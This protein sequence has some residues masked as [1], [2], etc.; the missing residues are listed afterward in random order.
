MDPLRAKSIAL[1]QRVRGT[2]DEIFE[3]HTR[4]NALAILLYLF[5][6]SIATNTPQECDPETIE[7]ITRMLPDMRRKIEA[8]K[9]QLETAYQQEH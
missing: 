1:E 3:V 7:T 6:F 2:I 9:K 4:G 8:A 5:L